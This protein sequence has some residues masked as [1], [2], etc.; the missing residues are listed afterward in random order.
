MEQMHP[1]VRLKIKRKLRRTRTRS[2]RARRRRPSGCAL[3]RSS[4]WWER[5]RRC[6]RGAVMNT[7]PPRA[8]PSILCPLTPSSRHARFASLNRSTWLLC[9]VI[10]CWDLMIRSFLFVNANYRIDNQGHLSSISST[11]NASVFENVFLRTRR[12]VLLKLK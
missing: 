1:N 3:R 12:N 7:A 2:R 8:T 4:W 11:G 9:W 6:A 10:V 5:V